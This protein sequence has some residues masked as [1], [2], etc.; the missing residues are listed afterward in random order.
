MNNKLLKILIGVTLVIALAVV[1]ILLSSKVDEVHEKNKSG[2]ESFGQVMLPGRDLQVANDD[3][4]PHVDPSIA[5]KRLS[6]SEKIILSLSKEKDALLQE[7]SD[8]HKQIRKLEAELK[9]LREFKE[10]SQKFGGLMTIEDERLYANHS[11]SSYLME[12]KDASAFSDF[13]REVMAAAAARAYVDILQR[14]Q[15]RIQR[16]E[17]QQLMTNH[18]PA[19]AFCLGHN[20]VYVPNNGVEQKMLLEF[21]ET[22]EKISNLPDELEADLRAIQTPCLDELNERTIAMLEQAP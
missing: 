16:D 19:Y 1:G 3:G 6:T 21:F 15:I 5:E 11:I 2:L 12:A 22:E 18:L 17:K 20:I 8:S 4:T 13:Q 9:D 10:T 14:F 7:L